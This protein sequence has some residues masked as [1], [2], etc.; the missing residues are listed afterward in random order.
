MAKRC[1]KL[2]RRQVQSRRSRSKLS[3]SSKQ[4]GT[5]RQIAQKTRQSGLSGRTGELTSSSSGVLALF[6]GSS[7]TRKTM[8]A[9]VIARELRTNLYRVNLNQ[10]VSKYIGETEKNLSRIF[11]A[12]QKRRSVLLFDEA[13]A[14]LGKRSEVK[15]RHDRYAN[16]EVSYLLSKVEAHRGLVILTTNRKEDFDPKTLCRVKYLLE[17]SSPIPSPLFQPRQ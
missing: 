14:L 5:F 15:D 13:D 6:Y 7:G 17:F 3:F 16:I 12:D 2:T 1:F 8:A 11:E 10:V 4:I 9:E